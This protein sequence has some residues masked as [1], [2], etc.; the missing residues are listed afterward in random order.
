[1][2]FLVGLVVMVLITGVALAGAL[3]QFWPLLV[4]LVLV[5]RVFR[6]AARETAPSRPTVQAVPLR[7]VAPPQT[8]WMLVPVWMPAPP[9]PTPR[10][11]IDAEVL[12][13]DEGW[14]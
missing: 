7:A 9:A 5:R 11:C 8:V 4:L 6:E 1:M 13:T 14:R 10:P 3:V 12:G 2:R